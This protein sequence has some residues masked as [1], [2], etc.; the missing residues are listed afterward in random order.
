[1]SKKQQRHELPEDVCSMCGAHIG[2]GHPAF[3]LRICDNCSDDAVQVQEDDPPTEPEDEDLITSDYV[4]FFRCG[5]E[6]KAPTVTVREGRDWRREVKR[7]MLREKWFPN[8]WYLGER[9]DRNLLD[10]NTGGYAN[11]H[12]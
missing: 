12:Q 7:Y 8:V 3:H 2:Y 6:H 10:L 1:M 4:K 5:F 9:G 11:E